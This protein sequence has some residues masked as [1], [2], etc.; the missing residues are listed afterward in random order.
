M[1]SRETGSILGKGIYLGYEVLLVLLD[2]SK[3][4][5]PT[6]FYP[7]EVSTYGEQIE[8]KK[9]SEG[10]TARVIEGPSSN[11]SGVQT[12]AVCNIIGDNRTLFNFDGSRPIHSSF[13]ASTPKGTKSL[14]F[15][16]FKV[17]TKNNG[18]F[19]IVESPYSGDVNKN[20]EY[21]N[22]AMLRLIKIGHSPFASHL[23]YTQV[24]DD[25]V[26]EDRNL[27]I[28]SG[29]RL[30][31]Y[32]DECAVFC[33][34]GISHGMRQGIERAIKHRVAISIHDCNEQLTFMQNGFVDPSKYELFL[35]WV[36]K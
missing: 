16:D 32:A 26:E 36:N 15:R 18:K 35:E 29:L 34:H 14:D 20:I 4:L 27:G 3:N 5:S 21:A 25:N 28:E 11:W 1:F 30:Y 2:S 23:L 31:E 22:E 19:I 8:I 13:L 9:V 6:L 12:G 24:L 17:D 7:E 33:R 10:D